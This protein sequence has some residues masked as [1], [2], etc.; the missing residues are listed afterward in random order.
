MINELNIEDGLIHRMISEH[1]VKGNSKYEKDEEVYEYGKL[2][3]HFQNNLPS[4]LISEN[5]DQKY[6][7]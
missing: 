2:F 3:P 7:Y 5:S 4:A 6:N 1:T